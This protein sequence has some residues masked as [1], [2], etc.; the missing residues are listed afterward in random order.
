MGRLFL[1]VYI[2]LLKYISE[3]TE[4]KDKFSCVFGVAA[5]MLLGMFMF[6]IGAPEF[7]CWFCFQF[8]LLAD[9]YPGKQQVMACIWESVLEFQAPDVELVQPQHLQMFGGKETSDGRPLSLNLFQIK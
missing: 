2:T 9:A 4:K 5:K 6:P 1:L 7:K 8:Y 3:L